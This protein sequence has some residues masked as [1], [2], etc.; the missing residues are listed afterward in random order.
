MKLGEE[1]GE[2]VREPRPRRLVQLRVVGRFQRPARQFAMHGKQRRSGMDRHMRHR[3]HHKRPD[4]F[5]QP[6]FP[7]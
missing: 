5:E 7:Q 3:H 1:Q 4:G 6:G 2:I